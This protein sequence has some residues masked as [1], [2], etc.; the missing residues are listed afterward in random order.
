MGIMDSMKSMM[1][2]QAAKLVSNV[3]RKA[4]IDQFAKLLWTLTKLAK[5]PA[6]SGLR[7]LAEGADRHDPMLVNWVELF[8]RSNPKVVEKVINNLIINEFAV[9]EKVRQEK[10][11]ELKIVLPKLAIISP[12]YACNLRC[13]GCYAALYGHK[14]QLSK[15][16]VFSVIRQFNDLGIYFFI[17]TGGEPFVYPYFYDILEEFQDSYFMVYTNATMINED[18]AKRL[19]ELGN[20]TFAISVEGDEAMTDWRRGKGIYKQV[21][22]AWKLMRENGVIFGSSITA[23]RKNHEMIMDDTFW[24]YL[25]ESGVSYAWVFQFMPV[26]ADATMEL[27]PT[28]EQRLERFRKTEELRLGGKFSFVADFW[29]HGFLSH[30]CLAA[31]SKY[32]HINAKGY[33]EPCIFQQFAVD[34]IREKSIVE[35]LSSP[36]FEAYKRTIP[37]SENL[38]RPC[39]IIDNPKVYRAM[40]KKFNAIPQ[41]PGSERIINELA[42]E[43][44]QLAA[45][46]KVYADKLWYEEGYAEKWPSKR[47]IYNYETRMRRYENN[48]EKLALDKKA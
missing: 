4:D 8:N 27:V 20:A 17:I 28:A 10:M 15:E 40:V 3:V 41:H 5:E 39:P 14:Y 47:G 1:M 6:K 29:N 44:D 46:W 12:T 16:E 23:T 30:G 43:L 18:S 22:N 7:H 37:Y 34:N 24:D 25:K 9:G 31:G 45:D 2:K 42:P 32:L 13:V 33:A 21:Q 11:H 19:A 36:F 48:E 26:G 38:F 35:I